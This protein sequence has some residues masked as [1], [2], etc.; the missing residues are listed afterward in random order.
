MW[1]MDVTLN[2]HEISHNDTST[3]KM[4]RVLGR[5]PFHKKKNLCILKEFSK[6]EKMEP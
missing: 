6:F 3:H 1:V 2:P 5:Y 4:S